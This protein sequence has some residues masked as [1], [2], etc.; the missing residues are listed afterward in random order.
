[1]SRNRELNDITLIS[2]N[3]FFSQALTERFGAS[4]N[5]GVP[6][7]A[8]MTIQTGCGEHYPRPI[9]FCAIRSATADA[10]APLALL[11]AHI[12]ASR[13]GIR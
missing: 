10:G 8:G 2:N 9:S 7:K 3:F 13:P 1:M 11:S 12:S 6:A 4:Y 5:I